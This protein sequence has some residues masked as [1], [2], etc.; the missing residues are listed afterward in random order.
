[1]VKGLSTGNRQRLL[2]AKTLL[3]DPQLLVL[4]EPASGLDPRARTELRE[5]VKTLAGLG[6]TIIISSHILPD[7]EEISDQIGILEAGKLVLDGELASLREKSGA[8]DRILRI[9]V[10]MSD[11]ERV[12]QMISAL[13]EVKTCDQRDQ[14]LVVSS[15]QPNGNFLLKE[16]VNRGV[17]ILQFAED[18][19]N[20]EEIFMRS[21]AGNVT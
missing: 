3:H 8:T 14:F 12:K 17:H 16:L 20:L 13:P 2:L 9:K 7:I 15:E 18:E 1:M 10:A 6:K 19:P 21:T 5:I 4:D 11:M